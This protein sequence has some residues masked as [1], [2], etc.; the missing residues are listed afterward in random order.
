V[1]VAPQLKEEFARRLQARYGIEL[2]LRSGQ[3]TFASMQAA[4]AGTMRAAVL[5][6]GNLYGSN[7]DAAWASRALRNVDLTLTVSTKLNTGHVHGRGKTALIV[8]ALARDEESQATTQESMFNH[9]RLSA[10]G[11]PAVAGEMRSEVDIVASLA[12]RILPAGRF[13]WT[14]L[15]SHEHLR[16]AIADVVPGYGAI[17]AIGNAGAEFQIEGRT[18]HTPR[19]ATHDGRARFHVTPLPRLEVADDELRLTTLRSEGQFNTVVY[20]EEDVYRGTTRRD[21]I[22]VSAEDATAR[23]LR[24]GTRVNVRSAAGSMLATVNVIDIAPGS[25]AMYYPEA[26]VLVPPRLDPR[27]KTPAF[28]FVPVRLETV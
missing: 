20:D 3:D 28:K 26:N 9:V 6:G 15:R 17:A 12:E 2:P 23:G 13:D 4:A 25:A 11:V 7:P 5:L 18:F 21:V 24:E 19:F 10:G 22:L 8:P 14:A 1:G 27:S 16:R